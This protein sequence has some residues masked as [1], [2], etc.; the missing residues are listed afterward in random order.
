M[1]DAWWVADLEKFPNRLVGGMFRVRPDTMDAAEQE[2]FRSM[3]W[4][5]VVYEPDDE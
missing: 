4:R 3:L 5:M 2:I 1:N